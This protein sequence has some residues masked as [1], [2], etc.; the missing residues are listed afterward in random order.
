MSIVMIFGA[1]IGGMTTEGGG[2]VAFPVMTLAL[3][4]NPIV[5]RDFSFMI[6]SCGLTAA[7]FT[8]IF[9]GILVEWHSILFSTIGAIFGVIFG[10]E[11]VDPLMAPA[12]KKMTFVSVFFSFAIALFILNSEKK[13]KTFNKIYQ[14]TLSKAFILI[15]NGFV[16]GIFT[17][18]A[19]SGI[20]VYSFSILT[21]FFRISEKVATP[22]SVVLMAINSMVGFFWRQFMQNEIQQES[23]EYLSVCLPVVVIFAPIGS[24]L[25]SYLHRLTQASFI[26][27]LETIALISALIIIKPNWTLLIF[28]FCLI[29]GSLIFYMIM[30]RCGQKLMLQK[31]KASEMKMKTNDSA[32]VIDH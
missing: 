18:I 17:G 30:A 12:E 29:S 1:L 25:A 21:L 20:D 10:L 16:G 7:S 6:Q 22:T 19:G 23:W 28:T 5:A 14:F 27:I 11:I 24:F 32:I 15:I 13:R 31:M 9:N 8:I 26:Y 4:I 2:A 3:N